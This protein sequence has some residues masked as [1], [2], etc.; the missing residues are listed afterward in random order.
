MSI[1]KQ[2][3]R[4]AHKFCKGKNEA[5]KILKTSFLKKLRLNEI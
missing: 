5:L 1:K 2:D 4:R 3:S